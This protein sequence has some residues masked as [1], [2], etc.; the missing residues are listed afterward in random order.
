MQR[1]SLWLMLVILMACL[2]FLREPRLQRFDET[3]L[4]WAMKNAPATGA[5]VPLT[6]VE[7]G[8]DSM[9]PKKGSV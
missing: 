5:T 8:G 7:I 9:L 3:F 2:F 4:Q 1:P 6:I